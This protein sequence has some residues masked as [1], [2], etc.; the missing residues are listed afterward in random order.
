MNADK[1]T[2]MNADMRQGVSDK[3]V[4]KAFRSHNSP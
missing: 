4:F 3:F 2:Q 1:D